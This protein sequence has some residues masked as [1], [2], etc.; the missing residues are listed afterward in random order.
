[1]GLTILSTIAY[2]AIVV[3]D[4]GATAIVNKYRLRSGQLK[5]CGC[6]KEKFDKLIGQRNAA[7]STTH[8]NCRNGHSTPTYKAWAS[9]VKR[10]KSDDARFYGSYKRKGITVCN[11][12]IDFKAFLHDMGERPV[13]MTLDRINNDGNYEP[14][15]CRWASSREQA[16][17]RSNNTI[18]LFNGKSYTHAE[19]SR[20]AGISDELLHYRITAGWPLEKAV[21]VPPRKLSR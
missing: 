21:S 7:R 2:S 15:N 18:R 1:M 8:G 6:F 4:C 19:L 11:R 20:L 12:W 3:C 17:N 10:C 9:M 5:S 14:A 13:G 16:N